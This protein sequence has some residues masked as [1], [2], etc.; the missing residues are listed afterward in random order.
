MSAW[1]RVLAGHSWGNPMEELALSLSTGGL[2][3]FGNVDKG[4]IGAF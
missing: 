3:G 2:A 1:V 4:Q